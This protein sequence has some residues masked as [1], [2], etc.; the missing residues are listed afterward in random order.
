MP[1]TSA[2]EAVS[3]A[4]QMA[5][6]NEINLNIGC[7]ILRVVS[8]SFAVA[9]YVG[10]APAPS[11][12]PSRAA[13]LASCRRER[14]SLTHGGHDRRGRHLSGKAKRAFEQLAT[15]GFQRCERVQGQ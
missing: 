12:M 2:G 13:N 11:A 5:P 10:C 6:Q 15:S 4:M 14:K 3:G 9:I 7:P 1:P 8:R